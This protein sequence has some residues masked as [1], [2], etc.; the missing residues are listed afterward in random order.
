MPAI[1]AAIMA[2]ATVGGALI[3]SGA[4][5]SAANTQAQ[6]TQQSATQQIDL[7][8]QLYASNTANETPYMNAGYGALAAQEQ[9]LGLKPMTSDQFNS[10]DWYVPGSVDYSHPSTP[11]APTTGTGT[12][13]PTPTPTPTT[14]NGITLP[15]AL[16][17]QGSGTTFSNIAGNAAY[18]AYLREHPDQAPGAPTSPTTSTGSAATNFPAQSPAPPSSFQTAPVASQTPVNPSTVTQHAQEAIAAGADPIS[19]RARAAQLGVNLQ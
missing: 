19:V 7:L 15:P 13:T 6:A 1:P 2:V 3:T 17:G 10:G 16:A 12:T 18:A 9:L 8:K 11:T 14:G 4:S 5:K